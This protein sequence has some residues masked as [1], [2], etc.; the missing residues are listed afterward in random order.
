MRLTRWPPPAG[1]CRS[2][3]RGSPT[4]CCEH[5]GLAQAGAFERVVSLDTE[6]LI[7][8]EAWTWIVRHL[9]SWL[10]C[11]CPKQYCSCG[12]GSLMKSIFKACSSAG[13]AAVRRRLSRL[14]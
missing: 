8:M 6:L 13:E 3:G 5:L 11:L 12:D 9:T 14:P 10:G 7:C 2:V 4:H 1:Y